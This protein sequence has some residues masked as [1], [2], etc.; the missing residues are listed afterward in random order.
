MT[1][2]SGQLDAA[3]AA[4]EAKEKEMENQKAQYAELYEDSMSVV[5]REM[6]KV[7]AELLCEQQ[8]GG[9]RPGTS[10][11]QLQIKSRWRLMMSHP[12]KCTN[13]QLHIFVQLS[14]LLPTMIPSPDTR[15]FSFYFLSIL[16]WWTD[17]TS[18]LMN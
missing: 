7:R 2:L 15:V 13:L 1:K 14:L 9:P 10:P 5:K 12:K 6:L 17:L 18:P 3:K 11:K 4:M 8:E 16:L